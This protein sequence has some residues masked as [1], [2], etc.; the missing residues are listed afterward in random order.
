MKKI[1]YIPSVGA[2]VPKWVETLAG[3]G[4]EAAEHWSADGHGIEVTLR[5]PQE[6]FVFKGVCLA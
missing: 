4:V 3:L 2:K 6:Y 1:I 5:S